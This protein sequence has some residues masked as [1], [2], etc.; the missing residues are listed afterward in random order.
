MSYNH[1]QNRQILMIELE[2]HR[3]LLCKSHLLSIYSS[4]LLTFWTSYSTCSRSAKL[5]SRNFKSAFRSSCYYISIASAFL[6]IAFKESS[7]HC[8]I[9]CFI[10]ALNS[11]SYCT[12]SFWHSVSAACTS[13]KSTL[14]YNYPMKFLFV[15]SSSVVGAFSAM[16]RRKCSI[17]LRTL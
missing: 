5:S 15:S 3:H 2:F 9:S 7:W 8:Y 14:S 16:S 17:S 6:S 4:I 12:I 1:S 11:S 13:F 10:S